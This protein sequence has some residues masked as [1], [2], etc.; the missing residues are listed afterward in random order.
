MAN[1]IGRLLES[2]H[3][4][5]LAGDRLFNRVFG[6]SG[7]Q[8]LQP[9][10][11][12]PAVPPPPFLLQGS[13]SSSF[14]LR[15]GQC[16]R[17]TRDAFFVVN[18][19][20]EG[21]MAD[22]FLVKDPR[23]NEAL[24]KQLKYFPAQDPQLRKNLQLRFAREALVM[25]RIKSP[26]VVKVLDIDPQSP[27]A[28]YIMEKIEGKS[29][30]DAVPADKLL[31]QKLS[32][33][34]IIQV[35]DGLLAFERA[36]Q[37]ESKAVQVA[38]RDIKPD[39]ILLR[40]EGNRVKGAVLTD[41]GIVKVPESEQTTVHEL[42][43]SRGYLAPEVIVTGGTKNADQ[44]ADIFSLGAVLYW[45]LTGHEPF[46]NHDLVELACDPGPLISRLYKQRPGSVSREVWAA[47]FKALAVQP[48]QRFQSYAEMRQAF[49]ELHKTLNN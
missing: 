40:L 6:R 42:M 26:N 18:F 28:F 11:L 4:A 1:L 22:I 44:R 17:A 21:G 8:Q 33:V 34:I 35:L 16:V 36:C 9:A 7:R 38:H 24:L 27:P 2:R 15:I 20:A 41:F 10:Y 25:S 45:L 30:M 5:L 43:G 12:G 48:E 29:L 19:F 49:F 39:N 14:R 32:L 3:P 46:I 31:G 37:S 23:G 47:V 13:G